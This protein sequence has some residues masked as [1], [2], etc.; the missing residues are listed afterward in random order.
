MDTGLEARAWH[1]ATLV[2]LAGGVG[3]DGKPVASLELWDPQ[4]NRTQTLAAFLL[5]ARRAHTAVLEADGSVLM[6]GGVLADGSSAVQN[7]RFVPETGTSAVAVRERTSERSRGTA[8]QRVNSR[9]GSCRRSCERMAIA[10]F[11]QVAYRFLSEAPA[12]MAS[13]NLYAYV[14]NDPV[15]SVDPW[16]LFRISSVEAR[17]LVRVHHHVNYRVASPALEIRIPPLLAVTMACPQ[18]KTRA[19]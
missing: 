9:R 8:R 17:I 6:K 14:H 11:L 5:E 4:T 12:D 13:P 10:S 2:L 18:E 7:E 19:C 16:G 3:K 15:G 1:T